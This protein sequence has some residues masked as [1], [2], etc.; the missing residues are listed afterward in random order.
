MMMNKIK[1]EN[2][3]QAKKTGQ[4]A[5]GYSHITPQFVPYPLPKNVTLY[6][7]SV[8][9]PTNS[10]QFVKNILKKEHFVKILFLGKKFTKN[11]KFGE[12]IPKNS[13][14]CPQYK[15]VLKIF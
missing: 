6:C 5:P 10:C 11:E 9:F 8:F 13:H 15:R 12:Q 2:S 1:N 4:C 3:T 14:T 7:I